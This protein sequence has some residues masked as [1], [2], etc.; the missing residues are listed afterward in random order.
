MVRIGIGKIFT[1]FLV[2]PISATKSRFLYFLLMVMNF[3]GISYFRTEVSFKSNFNFAKSLPSEGLK[4]H[5]DVTGLSKKD[6]AIYHYNLTI[7]LLDQL[8]ALEQT[9]NMAWSPTT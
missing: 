8:I 3:L 9:N 4:S 5:P 6:S 2:S 1:D 7:R